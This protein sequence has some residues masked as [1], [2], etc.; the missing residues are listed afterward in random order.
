MSKII[1]ATFR[2]VD[3][4]ICTTSDLSEH[5]MKK[6][7]MVMITKHSYKDPAFDADEE[8][9]DLPEPILLE[10]GD[11]SSEGAQARRDPFGDSPG[12]VWFLENSRFPGDLT[13]R[14]KDVGFSRHQAYEL[15]EAIL[16][17]LAVVIVRIGDNPAAETSLAQIVTHNYGMVLAPQPANP[18][19][20]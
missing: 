14:F 5:G 7:D 9:F 6:S 20:S 11:H 10:M 12:E 3:D 17:G 16:A 8:Y 4:A 18:Y 13:R 19:V 2:T 1:Y 15:E